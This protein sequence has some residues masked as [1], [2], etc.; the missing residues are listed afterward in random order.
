[1]NQKLWIWILRLFPGFQSPHS[2]NAPFCTGF[3]I[4]CS[5]LQQHSILIAWAPRL[6][7]LNSS[8]F[9]AF[10]QKPTL[11]EWLISL[12]HFTLTYS[13]LEGRICPTLN[14]LIQQEF[15]QHWSH[16]LKKVERMKKV[17][18]L[19]NFRE[20]ICLSEKPTK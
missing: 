17:S 7:T 1:M 3:Y 19:K 5:P 4:C 8:K 6:G 11:S 15:H 12:I 18:F 10:F 14:S 20:V 13:C 9:S 16:W 2:W